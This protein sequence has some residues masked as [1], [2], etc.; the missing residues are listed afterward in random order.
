MTTDRAINPIMRIPVPWV[1][2]LV[3]LAGVG[4]QR[5][6]PIRIRAVQALY[7]TH[8]AGAALFAI[9]AVLAA[10]CLV[11]FRRAKTTTVPFENPSRLILSGPYRFTRNPMYVALTLAYVGESGLTVQAWPLLVLPLVLV[12]VHRVVIPV[13][14]RRLREL[15]GDTYEQYC[16]RVRRWI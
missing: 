11:R 2:V 10:V 6:F 15:F 16:A 8:I 12:Y 5:L 14:E 9:G 3:F 7:I 13:E 4:L 1:F